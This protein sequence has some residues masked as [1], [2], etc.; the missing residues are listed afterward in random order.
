M[1]VLELHAGI[2]ISGGVAAFIGLLGL[3]DA[4]VNATTLILKVTMH[5]HRKICAS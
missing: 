4:I 5:I 2:A 3:I 1:F